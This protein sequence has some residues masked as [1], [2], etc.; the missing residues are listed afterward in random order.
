MQCLQALEKISRKQPLPCL[1][2]GTIAAALAYI[3]F[4][5]TSIQVRHLIVVVVYVQ[6]RVV[7]IL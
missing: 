2:A 1:Q 6:I 4:F 3:D 5:S 7:L